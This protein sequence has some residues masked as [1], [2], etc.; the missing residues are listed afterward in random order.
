M[1]EMAGHRFKASRLG[2]SLA[3]KLKTRKGENRG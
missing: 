3:R 2:Q 1:S